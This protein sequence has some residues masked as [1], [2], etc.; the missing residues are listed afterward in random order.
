MNSHELTSPPSPLAS[1]LACPFLVVSPP[2]LSQPPGSL[3]PTGG[4]AGA[5]T[6][7]SSF[8]LP[9]PGFTWRPSI[10]SQHHRK[11]EKHNAGP[12]F[13]QNR[14]DKPENKAHSRP[15]PAMS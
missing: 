12:V 5:A 4:E 7:S 10:V 9:F 8:F 14:R 15:S 3:Y 1:H 6:L 2:P 11:K 13:L